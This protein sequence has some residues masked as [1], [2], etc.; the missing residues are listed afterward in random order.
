M[1]KGIGIIF[2]LTL[3]VVLASVGVFFVED[4]TTPIIED[5]QRAE[6]QAAVEG[7]YPDIV[8]TTWTVEDS[9][10][11]FSGSPITGAKEIKDGSNLVGIVYTVVFRGFSSDI[12]YVVGVNRSGEITGYQTISQNDTAGY[13]AQ[14]ADAENW[15]QFIGM[16]LDAAG[17][18]AFDGLSGAS[19]TTGAW[20]QS[21]AD[22]ASWHSGAGVFPE[23]PQI[24]VDA[25]LIKS[26]L[27]DDTLVVTELSSNAKAKLDTSSIDTAYEATGD[28]GTYIVYIETYASYEPGTTVFLAVDKDTHE[29]VLFEVLSNNDTEG[30]GRK[31]L[32]QDYTQLEDEG[33]NTLINGAFDSISGATVTS[34]AWKDAMYRIAAFHQEVFQG[35]ITY[36]TDVLIPEYESQLSP[37]ALGNFTTWNLTSEDAVKATTS[38]IDGYF[39]L[40][41]ENGGS[42]ETNILL[43]QGGL[44]FT[45][46]TTY[47]ITFGG[48]AKTDRDVKII[49]GDSDSIKTIELT[50]EL[51]DTSYNFIPT[52]DLSDVSI[53]IRLGNKDESGAGYVSIS[54]IT[55]QEMDGFF[56]VSGSNQIVNE[57][58]NASRVLDVTD[59]KFSNLYISEVHDI[60]NDL[61]E[62]QGTIYYGYTFGE[63]NNGPTIINFMLGVDAAGNYTGFRFLST[64]DS[65][66]NTSEIYTANYEVYDTPGYFAEELEGEASSG[67][68]TLTNV[69]GLETQIASIV[70]AINEIGRYHNEDYSKRFNESIDTAELTAAYPAATSFTEI[71]NDYDF[72]QG[73]VNV[74][75]A[76]DGE[77]LLGYVYAG[78]YQGNNSEILYTLGV[79][80]AGDIVN[81]NVY[82][83]TESWMGAG[84]SVNFLD[85]T[86]I[87]A[88]DGLTVSDYV[89]NYTP[90]TD[91]TSGG[92]S[93][94]VD[95][96]SGVSTTTGGD[97]VHFGL[98]DSVYTVLKFH[99]DNSV[100]GAS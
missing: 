7:V 4:I 93:T 19:V 98:I 56:P 37:I 64:T 13:G 81:L 61:D 87:D 3:V 72:V 86:I 30:I 40:N 83:G 41:Y 35:I 58:L 9:T 1:K 38:V 16:L 44:N 60:Y 49:I 14:I 65:V 70:S 42:S 21:F 48:L 24:D 27:A 71:Y 96:I 53:T 22:V 94:D 91:P 55:V 26:K 78:K 54:E 51:E 84:Q 79:D 15:E 80:A 18:G 74:Y 33:L 32:E 76:Y 25:A 28:S 57:T 62:I 89:T 12:T 90:N 82:S 47:R 63:Y 43:S 6:I 8:G 10:L 66:L 20:K 67:A 17:S 77:T 85:S 23:I 100:G 88:F 5:R 52:E 11:D 95:A 73:V 69:A 50:K 31:I 2:M 59:Q 36:S 92:E 45:A 39:T 68:I 34:D 29:T 99:V 97:G 46:D 75:E